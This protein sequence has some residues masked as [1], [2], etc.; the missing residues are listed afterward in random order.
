MA[1]RP[2]SDYSAPYSNKI[3]A[4]KKKAFA[5]G[6]ADQGPQKP[7]DPT[8]TTAALMMSLAGTG[9]AFFPPHDRTARTATD[10][11][12]LQASEDKCKKMAKNAATDKDT[13]T[14]GRIY[15]NEAGLLMRKTE[16]NKADQTVVPDCLKAF[17]LRRYHGLPV[18][19]HI[20]RRRTYK[21]LKASYY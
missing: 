11:R 18:S 2:P 13:A 6:M 4:K 3:I 16:Q 5:S 19:G 8:V 1:L 17:V 12:R 15:K 21:Q 10:F 20:G 14:V 9:E 7:E